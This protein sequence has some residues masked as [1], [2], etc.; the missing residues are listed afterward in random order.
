M[1]LFMYDWIFVAAC[2]LSLV[3]ASR[4][5]SSLRCMGFLLRWL[6]S[7]QSTVSRCMGFGRCGTWPQWLWCIGLVSP[8]HVGSSR[9][10]NESVSLAL[11]GRFLSTIPLGKFPTSSCSPL[12]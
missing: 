10:G 5:Y 11:A 4:S 12:V 9:P 6:L 8:W 3:A 1:Y 7:L 2:R